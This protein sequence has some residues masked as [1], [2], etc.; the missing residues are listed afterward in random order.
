MLS[1]H[2]QF[3]YRHARI[4]LIGALLAV[5][6]AVVYGM[7]VFGVLQDGGF[8]DETAP[9]MRARH[10]VE[11]Q[12]GGEH[13]VV[14]LVSTQGGSV[15]SEVNR[16]A[17]LGLTRE[18][19][20]ESGL[21]KVTSYWTT[22]LASLKSLDSSLALVVAHAAGD[23][24]PFITKYSGARGPLTVQVGGEAVADENVHDEVNR[25]LVV[26]ES[27]AVPIIL[28]LLLL[29]FGS[30]VS[31]MIPLIIGGVV[32]AGTFAQ[33]RFLGD[34]TDVSVF[35]VNLT[36][37]LGLGL[38]IDYALLLVSRFR[39]SLAEGA[40]TSQ[41]VVRTVNTAGRTIL[42]S[43]LAVACAL[44]TLLCF[45]QFFLRSFA[46]AG[47]GVVLVAVLAALVITPA[48]L[49][50]LGPRINALRLRPKRALRGAG[51]ETWARIAIRVMERPVLTALPV[52]L[53]LV[54]M[55]APLATA[56]F[57]T[58]DQGAL[59]VTSAGRQVADTISA[60][61][62]GNADAATD[63]VILGVPSREGMDAYRAQLAGLSGV[64]YV[65]QPTNPDTAA[66]LRH[67]SV[68]MSYPAKSP[69]AQRLT[70]EIR[71]LVGPDHLSILVS[72]HDSRLI[73]TKDSIR[74][75]LPVAGG[76][77]V[78]T[79][80]LVL[81][82][83]TGS[84][85]QPLRA[86]VLN[87]LGLGATMGAMA[88]IF[89]HGWLSDVLGFTPRPLDLSMTV[90]LLCIVFGLS[91]D[92]EVFLISRIKELHDTGLPT[93]HAVREG[94]A[95]TGR[96]VSAAASLLAVSFLAFGSSSVAFL[97]MFGLGAGLAVLIDATLIR[98]VLVPASLKLLGRLNWASPT[99]LR[100]LHRRVRLNET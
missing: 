50:L 40:T 2:A 90:L 47:I 63:I 35:A 98:G 88:W 87:A 97:Q 4:I 58:P 72:S 55:A 12:F 9:S 57:G 46:Y 48:L 27:I 3:I 23:V 31:A 52:V 61:F 6:A 89:E 16:Q 34:V 25:S 81:Y 62:P 82:L 33:L 77:I 51:S 7:G 26:A 71:S 74:E 92:Y 65:S 79:T 45:P 54:A 100:R 66:D 83:F 64:E 36:T 80:F 95:R 24:N 14:F 85:I 41:A 59:P 53:F 17:G 10:L 8:V 67:L 5:A 73:D 94:L 49:A 39:E 78:L 38:S 22:G 75:R 19:A 68:L 13:N 96:I 84:L 30:L 43:A 28:L 18:L 42:F 15:D 60:R 20:T 93:R 29:V 37:A 21:T 76:L 99:V 44:A 11:S 86:L 70:S 1:A 56:T 32:V 69:G 91:M